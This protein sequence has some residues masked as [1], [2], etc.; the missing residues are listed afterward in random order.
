MKDL[1]RPRSVAMIGASQVPFK[2]GTLGVEALTS[3]QF[4]GSIYFVNPN[5]E[6]SIAGRPIYSSIADL[7]DGVDTFVFAIPPRF[8]PESLEEAGEK[9]GRLAVIF[10]GGFKETGDEGR[11]LEERLRQVADKWS[12]KIMGPNCLGFVNTSIGLNASFTPAFSRL[13]PGPVSVITQSGGMGNII[14]GQLAEVGIGVSKWFSVGNRANIEF[15]DLL[16]YLGE[17]PETKIII[18]FLEGVDDGRRFLTAARNTASK[19]PVLALLAGYTQAASRC[20][21]SHTGSFAV[22]ERIYREALRQAGVLT[23]ESAEEVADVSL[24]LSLIFP[25]RE[26]KIGLLTTTAGPA[27]VTASICERNGVEVPLLGPS[28]RKEIE[29]I[30]PAE[31]YAGNPID[32]LATGWAD[33][34]TYVKV[35]DILLREEAIAG[36]IVF[37]FPPRNIDLMFPLNEFGEMAARHQKPVLV[38]YGDRFCLKRDQEQW[39]RWKIPLYTTPERV[40]RVAVNLSRLARIRQEG[41]T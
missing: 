16:S 3:G 6:G 26:S 41:C 30:I 11:I 27:I 32:M 35:S 20:A 12:M 13:L 37:Y 10:S 28:T 40:A 18:L 4:E 1:F 19:K 38:A 7:P 15:A 34:I 24:A 8:I 14:L 23:L 39:A 36:L 22:S 25:W 21:L 33:P 5:R 17:D 2:V 31:G 29:K 9:G